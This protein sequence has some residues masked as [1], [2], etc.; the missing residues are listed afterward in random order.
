MEIKEQHCIFKYRHD[1]LQMIRYLHL[2][3]EMGGRDLKYSLLTAYFLVTDDCFNPL[4]ELS[5]LIKPDDDTYIVS[6]QGM[7]VNQIN[8]QEHDKVALPYKQAKTLL[9]NFLKQHANGGKLT[10][11][12]HG[13]KGDIEHLIDKLISE[14]SWEQ[15]CTYHYIDTSVVL[16]FLRVCGKMPMDVDGSVGALAKHFNIDIKGDLHDAC[17]DVETTCAILQKFVEL[18][19]DI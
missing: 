13:V 17:V 16:Q 8:L 18:N 10:P 11:V 7:T 1:I 6:G 15:F 19:N 14:G 5:L 4:G 12:G 2:D 3:C 9:F